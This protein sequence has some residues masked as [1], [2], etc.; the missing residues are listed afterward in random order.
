MMKPCLVC[1][2]PSTSTRCEQ[3]TEPKVDN[4]PRDRVTR[5]NRA[6]WKNLSA[7][8]RRMQPWC[9]IPGCDDTDLT[10][11]HIIP[12]AEGGAPYDLDNLRV[13]C[14]RHNSARTRGDGVNDDRL[15]P[16]YKAES[17]SLS[18]SLDRVR[19]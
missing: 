4:R 16:P 19:E 14:R 15:R 10:I 6:P 2:E 18:D 9:S 1:G 12:L 11:D 8:L 7:R 13:L 3:H 5:T 17:E